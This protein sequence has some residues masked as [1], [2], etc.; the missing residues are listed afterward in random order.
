[1]LSRVVET[2]WRPFSGMYT[3]G[4]LASNLDNSG[5]TREFLCGPKTWYVSSAGRVRSSRGIISYGTLRPSGYRVVQINFQNIYVH[6]LVACAFLG[7]PPSA[8]QWQVNHLD[9][10]RSNNH[11]SNLEN[12]TPRQNAQHSWSIRSRHD[13]RSGPPKPVLGRMCGGPHFLRKQRQQGL[14]DFM[15]L[16]FLSVAVAMGPYA[17][18]EE[19]VMSLNLRNV[20]GQRRMSYGKM[21]G[22]Q[23]HLSSLQFL[24]SG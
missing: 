23:A 22:I 11:L 15:H 12:A 10:C 1:M 21:P 2:R 7:Q 20:R 5:R 17:D 4:T 6:R 3:C 9:C 24:T 16:K 19:Q 8:E 13:R 14:L 18:F